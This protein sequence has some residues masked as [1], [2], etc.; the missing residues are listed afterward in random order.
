MGMGGSSQPQGMGMA[1]ANVGGLP[2]NPHQNPNFGMQ[3]FGGG[4][5]SSGPAS[6]NELGAGAA[7]QALKAF[8]SGGSGGGG[9]NQLIGLE[10]AEAEKL[11][12]QQS[13]NGNAVSCFSLARL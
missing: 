13:A 8:T 9:Q 12:D 11:F 5:G 6:S 10:M 2:R 3:N 4:G 1:M 7:M